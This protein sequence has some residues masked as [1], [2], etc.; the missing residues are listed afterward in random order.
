MYKFSKCGSGKTGRE[1]VRQLMPAPPSP[2][3]AQISHAMSDATSA[4][5]L[6]LHAQ[7]LMCS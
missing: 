4:T 7:F 6:L 2:T 1:A 3:D 5:A